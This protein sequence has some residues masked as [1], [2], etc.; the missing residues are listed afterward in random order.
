V[1][2]HRHKR[3]RHEISGLATKCDLRRRRELPRSGHAHM[4][5]R[6]RGA[7]PRCAGRDVPGDRAVGASSP[8]R[9]A[10][11]DMGHVVTASFCPRSQRRQPRV[12]PPPVTAP[13][14]AGELTRLSRRPHC[15]RGAGSVGPL[16]V[17]RLGPTIEGA[18]GGD[19]HQHAARHTVWKLASSSPSGTRMPRS[20]E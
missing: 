16:E 10:P 4:Y 6:P 20:S 8:T 12:L 9:K 17:R 2:P 5:A 14:P 19:V 3:P 18:T 13:T 11:N 15:D 1:F 7:A